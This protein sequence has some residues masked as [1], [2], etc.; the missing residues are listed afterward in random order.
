MLDLHVHVPPPCYRYRNT[1]LI[2]TPA[3]TF[4]SLSL[5]L[6]FA[7][8]A[9][10]AEHLAPLRR[11]VDVGGKNTSGG[12]I[13]SIKTDTVDPN[14]RLRWLTKVLIAQN[15]TIDATQS[16]KLGWSEDIFN[17]LAGILSTDAINVLRRQPEVAWVEEGPSL[18]LVL[19]LVR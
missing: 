16:L 5:S 8:A 6:S 14:N 12:Y 11:A 19:V 17:G 1:M 7:L 3:L 18:G 4:L 2:S 13:V 9:P 10:V 15:I